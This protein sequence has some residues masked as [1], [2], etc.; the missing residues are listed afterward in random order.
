MIHQLLQL[1]FDEVTPVFGDFLGVIFRER[2]AQDKP[3]VV[4]FRYD[5]LQWLGVDADTRGSKT[6]LASQI[7]VVIG[8]ESFGQLFQRNILTMQFLG[9]KLG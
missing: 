1:R 6:L 7:K 9:K 4:G 3:G 8:N 2:I 5:H